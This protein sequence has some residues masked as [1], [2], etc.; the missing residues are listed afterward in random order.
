VPVSDIISLI[1]PTAES[2]GAS[3]LACS[4]G[5]LG[6]SNRTVPLRSRRD[7]L[8]ADHFVL[9]SELRRRTGKLGFEGPVE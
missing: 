7:R 3:V 2:M 4:E 8:S 9:A 5:E 6:K 1:A